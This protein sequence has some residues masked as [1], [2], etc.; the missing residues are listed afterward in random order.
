VSIAF[1][2][3]AVELFLPFHHVALATV[4]LDELTEAVAAL[5]GAFRAFDA[6]HVE[7]ALDIAK[8]EVGTLRHDVDIITR[9]RV[10]R[11]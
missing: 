4:F 6:Q 9:N 11:D 10:T 3:V 5:A 1:W 7:L 8:D 2:A